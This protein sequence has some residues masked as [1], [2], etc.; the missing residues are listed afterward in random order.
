MGPPENRDTGAGESLL[1]LRNKEE[2]KR[3]GAE[4]RTEDLETRA[5]T[6]NACRPGGRSFDV[7]DGQAFTL[8]FLRS[9]GGIFKS[10]RTTFFSSYLP[11]AC[12]RPSFLETGGG[13][14][15]AKSCLTRDLMDCSLPGSS[16]HGISRWEHWR[17]LLF[18]SPGDLPDP[19]S[20]PASPTSPAKNFFTAKLPGK[21]L[22]EAEP[23]F[24]LSCHRHPWMA[25]WWDVRSIRTGWVRVCVVMLSA[26]LCSW[27]TCKNWVSHSPIYTLSDH[28]LYV[29]ASSWVFL[30]FPLS[31]PVTSLTWTTLPLA[32]QE[33]GTSLRAFWISTRS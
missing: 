21:P 22:L 8:S 30:S 32:C 11:G 24:F 14:L 7:T 28:S 5:R 19:G 20:K 13:V 33:T 31:F 9:L 3:V 15:V 27:H 4:T 26:H 12:F 16:V 10:V 6:G 1:Y 23:F 25:L 18:P 2:R 29:Q 17:G